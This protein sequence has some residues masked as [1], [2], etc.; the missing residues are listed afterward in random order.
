M[1][2]VKGLRHLS[3][4]EMFSVALAKWT[5][6]WVVLDSKDRVCIR[7]NEEA[8]L[9]VDESGKQIGIDDGQRWRAPEQ[10]NGQ[11]GVN[12]ERVSVFRLGLVLLEMRT[13]VIPFGEIDGTNASRQVCAG[14][15]PP[16]KDVDEGF[17]SIVRECLTINPHD[18]PLL[19]EV[20]DKLEQ[21]AS[22]RKMEENGQTASGGKTEALQSRP[23]VEFA[24]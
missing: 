11:L 15:L 12:S 17:M 1:E 14:L 23:T 20:E 21:Y 24:R 18:R 13:G 9:H 4:S 2:I 16:H 22:C 8:G 7:L 6:H 5:P 19:M 3:K 10:S